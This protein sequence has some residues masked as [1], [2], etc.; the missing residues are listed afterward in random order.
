MTTRSHSLK[1][2]ALYGLV[3]MT[4]AGLVSC[5]PPSSPPSS[6]QGV[7]ENPRE[8]AGS[9][10]APDLIVYAVVVSGNP[11]GNP[12]GGSISLSAGVRNA[13]NGASAATTLRY[14]RSTDATITTSDTEVG[15]DAVGALAA[16]ATSNEQIDDLTLPSLAGTYYYGACIDSVAGESGTTNNCSG[17]VSVEVE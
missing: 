10:A 17:P 3:M 14:Y 1:G 11:F 7:L 9:A 6:P 16:S 13:G 12:P 4:C 15:T 8:P 5:G 2:I